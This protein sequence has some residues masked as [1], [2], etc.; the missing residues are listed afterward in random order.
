MDKN[1][2]CKNKFIQNTICS[3]YE[4]EDFL[5]KYNKF[6]DILKIIKIAKRQKNK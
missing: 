4:A 5:C 1:K 3:L 2:K 6:S